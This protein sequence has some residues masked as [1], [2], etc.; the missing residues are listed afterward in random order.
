[1]FEVNNRYDSRLPVVVLPDGNAITDGKNRG[2]RNALWQMRMIA[3]R[4]PHTELDILN[5]VP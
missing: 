4:S 1:L 5:F 3:L 2:F